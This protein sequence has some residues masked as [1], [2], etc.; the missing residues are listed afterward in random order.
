[1]ELLD[2]L[3]QA[4]DHATKVMA[5]VT[6]DQLGAPTPCQEWDVRTLAGHI[7]HVVVNMGR[8]ARGEERLPN[9]AAIA[10]EPDLS[11]QFRTA[12]DETLAAWTE[13]GTDGTVDIGAGPMPVAVALGVNVLDTSTHS[14]DLARA[15][16]QAA[17]LPDDLA[18]TA[19]TVAEGVITDDLRRFAGFDP[20]IT[21]DAEASPTDRLVAFLGR[22]P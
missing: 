12:A 13:R 9:L 8:G 1:M 4:C 21:V 11:A 17:E 18:Q 2:A 16:A 5:G 6:P 7:V 14:W 22:Q 15:T 10:L 20:P 3:S 19:L